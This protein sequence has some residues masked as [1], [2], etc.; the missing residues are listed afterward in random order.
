MTSICA[1][2]TVGWGRKEARRRQMGEEGG[3]S[4]PDGGGRRP[5]VTA[6]RWGREEARRYVV[7]GRR[8]PA[9]TAA[10]G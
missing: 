1:T 10:R 7:E 2:A 8:E 9:C 6:V 3:S 4:S 5:V